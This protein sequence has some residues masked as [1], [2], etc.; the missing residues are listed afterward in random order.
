MNIRPFGIEWEPA[1]VRVEK[2]KEAIR[3]IRLL[4]SSS[5][6][7]PVD[8]KGKYYRL[9]KTRLDQQPLRKPHPPIYT[10][11][12]GSAELLGFTGEFADG[13]YPF[14]NS[15]ETYAERVDE[16][17]RMLGGIAITETTRQHA[18]EMLDR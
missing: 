17:A 14:I 11:V 8:F 2:L 3:L 13:W 15:P 9:E 6:E 7:K 4:W 1:Q 12:F 16:I 5:Y 18:K 10:G